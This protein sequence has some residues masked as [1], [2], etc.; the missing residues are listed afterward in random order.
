MSGPSSFKYL[1]PSGIKLALSRT[2]RLLSSTNGLKWATLY[3]C[4]EYGLETQANR[5]QTRHRTDEETC[6]PA[7]HKAEKEERSRAFMCAGYE[8]FCDHPTACFSVYH[9]IQKLGSIQI[10]SIAHLSSQRSTFLAERLQILLVI[11]LVSL[12][13]NFYVRV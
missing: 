11:I 1:L 7:N 13:F 12:P 9:V 5:W 2:T 3:D 10:R 6:F 8:N 4:Y